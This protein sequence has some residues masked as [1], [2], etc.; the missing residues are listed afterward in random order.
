MGAFY[1]PCLLR[2][3]GLLV[4][5]GYFT[6]VRLQEKLST[7]RVVRHTG[8]GCTGKLWMPIPGSV[9]DQVRW[10]SGVV[11]GVPAYRRGNWN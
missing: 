3:V 8:I 11:E 2:N 6:H 5:F 10:G 4:S 9:H 1:M 7:M